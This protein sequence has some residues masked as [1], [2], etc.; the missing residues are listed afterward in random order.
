M[1]NATWQIVFAILS[2]LWSAEGPAVKAALLAELQ[3]L[4]GQTANPLL[5]A[6]IAEAEKLVSAS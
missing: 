2:A 4:A 3:A 6:L 5:A 1:N